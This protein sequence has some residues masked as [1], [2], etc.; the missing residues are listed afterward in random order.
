MTDNYNI[1][2]IESNISLTKVEDLYKSFITETNDLKWEL[3]LPKEY[4][5]KDFFEVVS[6][7]QF[8][9]TWFRKNKLSKIVLPFQES[10][11]TDDIERF[12]DEEVNYVA[13]IMGWNGEIVN[14]NGVNLKPI[15]KAYTTYIR[16]QM[17]SL[18]ES[19][20]IV[21][22]GNI[23]FLTCFDHFAERKGLLNSFYV[24]RNTFFPANAFEFSPFVERLSYFAQ[25]FNREIGV[26]NLSEIFNDISAIIYELMLNTHEWARTDEKYKELNPSV[27]GVYLKFHKASINTYISKTK[28]NLP[29][30]SFFKEP[31]F[32]VNERGETFLMEISVFD[33]GPG[34]VKRYT[35]KSG[36]DLSI[37]DQVDVVKKCLTRHST[38]ANGERGV[39]KGAGLDRILSILDKKGFLKIRTG[40][41]SLYRDMYKNHYKESATYKEIELFDWNKCSPQTY[42]EM[43]E[44]EGATI[45]I[46]YPYVL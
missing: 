32:S 39:L 21:Q 1:K 19:S 25:S 38:S 22:K 17:N 20:R 43:Q 6:Y 7:I 4:K 42:T 23:L 15:I 5:N 30:N 14:L 46:I 13:V 35:S 12:L 11:M 16:N 29:L 2:A 37:D 36:E 44:V 28:N 33:S 18:E 34:F 31:R 10:E 26:K 9:A 40:K 24:N 8:L 45:S 41:C 27:R 3:V